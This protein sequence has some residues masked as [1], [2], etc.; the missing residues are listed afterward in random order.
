MG[1]RRP[2][3]IRRLQLDLDDLMGGDALDLDQGAD[4]DV[5]D[6]DDSIPDEDDEDDEDGI[7]DGGIFAQ[8]INE[9]AAELGRLTMAASG[10]DDPELNDV[11]GA[12]WED[13][14]AIQHLLALA[15]ESGADVRS[16]DFEAAIGAAE[17]AVRTFRGNVGKQH[18]A[19][20][21][22]RMRSLP[23]LLRELASAVKRQAR[24]SRN[25]YDPNADD[26]GREPIPMPGGAEGLQ[27][28]WGGDAALSLGRQPRS[29]SV[30]DDFFASTRGSPPPPD[31]R[32]QQFFDTLKR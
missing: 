3:G 8:R 22:R 15:E 18:L 4:G 9:L 28:A 21:A 7:T 10:I 26:D 29:R 24:Q 12:A 31:P 25:E 19:E 14:R 23:K 17:E 5:F 32:V 6:M 2:L 20:L 27:P 1:T 11:R 30:V 16:A 13:L